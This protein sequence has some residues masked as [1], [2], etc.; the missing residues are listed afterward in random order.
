MLTVKNLTILL[1]NFTFDRRFKTTLNCFIVVLDIEKVVYEANN[2][3]CF[4]S[5]Y[6]LPGELI[7]FYFPLLKDFKSI[8]TKITSFTIQLQLN[9]HINLLFLN[10]AVSA[11]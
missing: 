5:L 3:S 2:S 8:E 1:R 10:P 9:F 6:I 4:V 7:E 11:F